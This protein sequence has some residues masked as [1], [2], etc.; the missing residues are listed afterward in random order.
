MASMWVEED[1]KKYLE[2]V[3]GPYNWFQK[4]Y[5]FSQENVLKYWKGLICSFCVALSKGNLEQAESSRTEFRST[6]EGYEHGGV[7]FEHWFQKCTLLFG[8][9][10]DLNLVRYIVE[11]DQVS[12][13][14][15]LERKVWKETNDFARNALLVAMENGKKD[16]VEYL[17]SDWISRPVSHAR[18]LMYLI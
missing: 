2:N 9:E 4:P 1:L 7:E 15:I 16:V 11:S 12:R 3:L 17:L 14:E 6:L 5:K 10:R 13:D 8:A 18:V